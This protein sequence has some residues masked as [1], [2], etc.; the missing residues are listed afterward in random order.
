L[1]K[2]TGWLH[3]QY[4]ALQSRDYDI[5]I[6][7]TMPAAERSDEIAGHSKRKTGTAFTDNAGHDNC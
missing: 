6:H 4:G 1:N 5:T 3:A 2:L 7:N